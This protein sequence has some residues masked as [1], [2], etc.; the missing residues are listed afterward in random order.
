MFNEPC[1]YW[2]YKWHRTCYYEQNNYVS[3]FIR[4]FQNFTEE[5]IRLETNSVDREIRTCAYIFPPKIRLRDLINRKNIL[6]N[7]SVGEKY[8]SD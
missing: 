2:P 8:Y 1:V 5:K 3:R 7:M 6:A 4:V